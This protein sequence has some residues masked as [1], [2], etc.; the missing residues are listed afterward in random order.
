MQRPH[1]V[2]ASAQQLGTADEARSGYFAADHSMSMA[3]IQA[4][5]SL[6]SECDHAAKLGAGDAARAADRQSIAPGSFL[7]HV[8]HATHQP[9]VRDGMIFTAEEATSQVDLKHAASLV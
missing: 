1:E 9:N 7:H 6:P 5:A 4:L 3:P 8:M 2:A